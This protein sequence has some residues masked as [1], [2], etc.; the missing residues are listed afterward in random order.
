MCTDCLFDCPIIGQ[1]LNKGGFC[2]FQKYFIDPSM[3]NLVTA[4][5]EEKGD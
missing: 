4:G 1:I 3:E 2:I 5:P